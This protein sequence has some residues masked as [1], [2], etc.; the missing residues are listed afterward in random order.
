MLIC[1]WN[2]RPRERKRIHTAFRN[3]REWEGLA[4]YAGAPVR[5]T[6]IPPVRAFYVRNRPLT[7]VVSSFGAP[8]ELKL[9]AGRTVLQTDHTTHPTC[10]SGRTARPASDF[11]RSRDF[12]EMSIG[13]DETPDWQ[14]IPAPNMVEYK[15]AGPSKP[16]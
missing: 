3:K 8:E 1:P 10:L 16:T 12:C 14:H 2:G 13:R 6:W 4:G 5:R 11:S 9:L 15:N 7:K